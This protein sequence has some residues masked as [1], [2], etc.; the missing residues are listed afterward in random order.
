[1]PRRR[2]S[3]AG[4]AAESLV[5]FFTRGVSLST[6][7]ER[8][9]LDREVALYRALAA[10]VG[11]V[12]FVT[13]G[14]RGDLDFSDRLGSDISVLPNARG[15]PRRAYNQLLPLLHRGVL[16]RAG[17]LKTNQVYGGIAA[18][19]AARMYRRPLVARC[20]FLW[21][22]VAAADHG[23]RSLRTRFVV[24][25]ERRLLRGADQVVVTTPRLKERVVERYAIPGERVAVIPNYVD[26]SLFAPPPDRPDPGSLVFVGRLSREKNLEALIE[27]VAG[28]DG[29]S[30]TIVGDGPLRGDLERWTRELGADVR[31][32]GQVPH[33][34]LPELLAQA[35]AFAL[36]SFYEG[37]PKAAVEAMACGLP[38]VGTDVDGIRDLVRDG[39]TGVLSGTSPSELRVSIERVLGDPALRERMGRAARDE[40]AGV[41]LERVVELEV[42]VLER[43]AR[44]GSRR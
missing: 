28:L 7:D 16:R 25:R 17:V 10:R 5:L 26:T 41:S 12:A 36:P 4:S 11:P 6:W 29:V 22:E 15:L 33:E 1:M 2:R 3:S 13:Y 30:L 23:P 39:E 38:V 37:H 19:R 20:G 44:T 43:A 14:D 21:S 34:R 8:G 9:I 42:E 40:T 35:S 18:L 27:A 32:P 31:F 24:D